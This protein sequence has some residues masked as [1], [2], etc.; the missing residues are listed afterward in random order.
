MGITPA[1]LK[2]IKVVSLVLYEQLKL[3]VATKILDLRV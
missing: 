3:V 2:V 1:S